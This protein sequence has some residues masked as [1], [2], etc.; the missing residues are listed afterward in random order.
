[1]WIHTATS[2]TV[3]YRMCMSLSMRKWAMV[4]E[5]LSLSVIHPP[6]IKEKLQTPKRISFYIGEK[7][8]EICLQIFFQPTSSSTAKVTMRNIFYIYIFSFSNWRWINLRLFNYY[9]ISLP[10][11]WTT[12]HTAGNWIPI[13]S[14]GP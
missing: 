4:I 5:E 10:W 13:I 11:F 14:K 9:W 3:I 7:Y 1:M 2:L 12:G 8:L 6:W